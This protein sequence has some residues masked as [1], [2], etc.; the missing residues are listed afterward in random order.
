MKKKLKMI[1]CMVLSFVLI[2]SVMGCSSSSSSS[3]DSDEEE[4]E[5]EEEEEEAEEEEAEEETEE[6]V[7]SDVELNITLNAS[8]SVVATLYSRETTVTGATAEFTIELADGADIAD[9]DFSNVTVAMSEGDG[10]YISEFVDPIVTLD[11]EGWSEDGTYTFSFDDD[12]VAALFTRDTVRGSESDVYSTGGPDWS[13]FGGNGNGQYFFN[14]TVSGITYQ[15]EE[16]EDATFRVC[17]YVYGRD[18]SDKARITLSEYINVYDYEEDGAEEVTVSDAGIDTEAEDDTAVW[19]WVGDDY[20]GVPILCDT[21][22]DDFYITWPDDVD[23]SSLTAE[24]ITI[25]L[26]SQYGDEYV[27][28]PDSDYYIYTDGSV[29]QLALPFVYMPFTPVYT[30]MVISIDE[31]AVDVPDSFDTD[32]L[33]ISYDIASVYVYEIQSGGLDTNGAVLSYQFYGFDEDSLT[34]WSQIMNGFEYVLYIEGDDGTIQYYSEENGGT[35]VTDLED[36]TAYDATGAEDLNI[37]LWNQTVIYDTTVT[38]EDEDGNIIYRTETK[39]VDGE[40]ITFIKSV[41][42]GWDGEDLR[43]VLMSP[44]EATANGLVAADGYCFP[45]SDDFYELYEAYD[46]GHDYWVAHSMWP[47]VEGIEVGWLTSSDDGKAS[48]NGLEK[49]YGYE[50]DSDGSYPDWTAEEAQEVDDWWP[51]LRSGFP[52]DCWDAIDAA[53]SDLYEAYSVD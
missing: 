48:W 51:W 53:L 42:Y 40:E 12:T 43:G 21:L 1:L 28:T 30:D 14:L 15:G 31:S 24:D 4:A 32:T 25:T 50:Y 23:A 41:E 7:A 16:I 38:V 27:L 13:Q 29:T 20:A 3:S 9:V 34:D 22:Q 5:E 46:Y 18:A 6:E 44:S 39:E 17:Y 33:T 11:S 45:Q 47:W 35:L 2:F 10:Y 26:Y 37:R 36:A 19:T 49:G 8:E 52:E